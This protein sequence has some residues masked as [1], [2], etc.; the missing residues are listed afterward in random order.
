M[1]SS[2]GVIIWTLVQQTFLVVGRNI[3]QTL[4]LNDTAHNIT[5]QNQQVRIFGT[6][7]VELGPGWWDCV[8]VIDGDYTGPYFDGANPPP[9]LNAKWS[10]VPNASQSLAGIDEA[11]YYI[12]RWKGERANS[13][14]ELT[15]YEGPS[16]TNIHPRPQADSSLGWNT[17]STPSGESED[18]PASGPSGLRGVK[19]LSVGHTARI[20][21]NM[22]TAGLMVS[23]I[24]PGKTYT[25]SA[26]VAAITNDLSVVSLVI[27]W[28]NGTTTISSKS[29]ILDNISSEPS[30]PS[31]RSTT[32]TAPEGADNCYTLLRMTNAVE[33]NELYGGMV[34]LEEAGVALPYFDGDQ[35]PPRPVLPPQSPTSGIR[36][37]LEGN[38]QPVR[39]KVWTNGAFI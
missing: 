17:Y 27:G 31:R 39:V 24:V 35:T 8:A 1:A 34:L 11:V 38:L 6:G 25:M 4:W 15:T 18:V 9:G 3:G 12:S 2:R 13:P 16:R 36:A 14:S 37:M 7:P 28:R 33:G 23:G 22:G 30:T 32:V 20:E 26:S 29:I 5:E 19:S 10:D 21:I